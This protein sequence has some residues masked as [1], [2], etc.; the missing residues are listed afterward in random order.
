MFLAFL[1][2]IFELN[3]HKDLVNVMADALALARSIGH[4]VQDLNI[5]GGLGIRYI[6]SDDPPSIDSWIS[7]I[8]LA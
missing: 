5:G 1:T 3:P 8:S 7:T 4:P 2:Q 6:A